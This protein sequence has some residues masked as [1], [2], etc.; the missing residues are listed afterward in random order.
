M[1]LQHLEASCLL[2]GAVLLETPRMA[3]GETERVKMMLTFSPPCNFLLVFKVLK[4]RP[5]KCS[6]ASLIEE[7]SNLA[8]LSYYA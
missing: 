1:F 3:Q 5:A 6:K 8:N 2:H 7:T 4:K